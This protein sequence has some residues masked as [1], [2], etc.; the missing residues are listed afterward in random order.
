MGRSVRQVV[1]TSARAAQE[2]LLLGRKSTSAGKKLCLY[3]EGLSKLVKAVN[4]FIC[5]LTHQLLCA[6]TWRSGYD[7]NMMLAA[8]FPFWYHLHVSLCCHVIILIIDFLAVPCPEGGEKQAFMVHLLFCGT[9]A[10]WHA[11]LLAHALSD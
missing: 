11:C 10:C 2:F 1:V 7:S 5:V 4:T 6:G 3:V 9:P 8:A